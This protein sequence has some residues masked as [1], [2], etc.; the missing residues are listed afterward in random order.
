LVLEGKEKGLGHFPRYRF[1][2]NKRLGFF[3]SSTLG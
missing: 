1:S 3:A 2:V